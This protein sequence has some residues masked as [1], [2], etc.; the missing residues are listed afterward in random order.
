MEPHI[1][2]ICIGGTRWRARHRDVF[3]EAGQDGGWYVDGGTVRLSG[4]AK[5]AE[6]AKKAAEAARPRVTRE[7]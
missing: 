7:A 2:W 4:K 6:A 1:H 3:M 5:D